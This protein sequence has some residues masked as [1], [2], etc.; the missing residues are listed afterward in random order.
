MS[1]PA[2]DSN[3]RLRIR[4]R[5]PRKGARANGVAFQCRM[6]L[7][8]LSRRDSVE[9]LGTVAAIATRRCRLDGFER[10]EHM[11]RHRPSSIRSGGAIRA[12]RCFVVMRLDAA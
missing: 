2:A 7:L 4:M 1:A 5:L 6:R 11:D 9:V 3:S 8:G 12:E 10:L